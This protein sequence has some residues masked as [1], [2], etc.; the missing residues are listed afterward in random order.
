[1]REKALKASEFSSKTTGERARV[2]TASVAA[3]AGSQETVILCWLRG[4][5]NEFDERSPD[6]QGDVAD[7][8]SI[9]VRKNNT[10]GIPCFTP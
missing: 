3:V 5:V 7:V 10:G 8:L 2:D 9:L 4:E 6:V 1:M